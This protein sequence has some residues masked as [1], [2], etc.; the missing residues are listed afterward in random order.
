VERASY[1]LYLEDTARFSTAV[2]VEACRRLETSSQWFPKLAELVEECQRVAQRH[3]EQ[4]EAERRKRLPPPPPR[5]EFMADVM[6]RLK[7]LTREKGMK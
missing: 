7:A 5:P 6:A 4:R 3:Q 1:V 2:V